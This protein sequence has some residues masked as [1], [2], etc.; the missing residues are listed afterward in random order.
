[1]NPDLKNRLFA[2]VILDTKSAPISY[3]QRKRSPLSLGGMITAVVMAMAFLGLI[4][5]LV[6][7]VRPLF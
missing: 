7:K 2:N 1:M 4:M 3:R 5:L 6:S